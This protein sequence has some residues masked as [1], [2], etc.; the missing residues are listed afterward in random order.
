MLGYETTLA[1]ELLR[2]VPGARG[3][4][5]EHVVLLALMLVGDPRH[6]RCDPRH[7]EQSRTRSSL[8]RL[9]LLCL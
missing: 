3:S 8:H 6:R 4:I 7:W 5:S 1:C 9:G 2:G